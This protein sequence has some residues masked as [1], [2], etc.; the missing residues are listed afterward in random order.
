MKCPFLKGELSSPSLALKN[1]IEIALGAQIEA[2]QVQVLDSKTIDCL[3]W[4]SVGTQPE[5]IL[6]RGLLDQLDEQEFSVLI[7]LCVETIQKGSMETSVRSSKKIWRLKSSLRASIQSVLDSPENW[8]TQRLSW[9]ESLQLLLVV[10]YFRRHLKNRIDLI[11]SDDLNPSDAEVYQRLK[12][13]SQKWR[14]QGSGIAGV[15]A[16]PVS[17]VGRELF[18]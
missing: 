12:L 6:S 8:R 1:S 2:V 9:Y 13:K 17:W 4:K 11:S 16:W 7:R 5:L 3:F 10:P 15:A 18:V 14:E